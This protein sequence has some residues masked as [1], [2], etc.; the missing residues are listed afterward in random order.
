[1]VFAVSGVALAFVRLRKEKE[2]LFFLLLCLGLFVPLF[3]AESY[4]F[5][6]YLTYHTFFYYIVPFIAIFS[7]VTLAFVVDTV[8]AAYSTPKTRGNVVLK[9]VAVAILVAL[10][11]VM[12]FVLIRFQKK[13]KRAP[14]L[15]GCRMCRL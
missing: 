12:R 11:A 5:G 10:V 7:A 3:F 9:V 13:C 8:F 1:L 6:L 4:L 2:L 15:F 14:I